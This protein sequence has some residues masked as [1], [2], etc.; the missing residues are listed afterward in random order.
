MIPIGQLARLLG[1]STRTL[2][3]YDAIGLFPPAV[4]HPENGYRYYKPAQIAHLQRILRLRRLN[5]PLEQIQALDAAGRLDDAESF[6]GFLRHHRDVLEAEIT[7]RSRL[8]DEVDLFISLIEKGNAMNLSPNFVDRPAFEVTG[9][10]VVCEDPSPIKALW[11]RMNPRCQEIVDPSQPVSWYGLCIRINSESFRYVACC[12]TNPG[13]PVPPEMERYSVPAQR[14]A[15]FTHTGP[16]TG[17]AE[18][19]RTIWQSL[20]PV[21][22]LKPTYGPDFEHYDERYLGP[23]HP[24]SQIDLYIPIE[25]T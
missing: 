9:L 3:H 14:Y 16:V 19:Y 5:V 17:L 21:W 22:N 13:A 8:L 12:G 2:R 10:S 15:R 6:A 23:D 4:I 24:D 25:K 20:E 18:T 7:E 11:A 1:I